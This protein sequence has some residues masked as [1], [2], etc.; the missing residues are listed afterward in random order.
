MSARPLL[1]DLAITASTMHRAGCA[2]STVLKV[3]NKMASEN[4]QEKTWDWHTLN[5]H[6]RTIDGPK[7]DDASGLVEWMMQRK[8]EHGLAAD[9]HTDSAGH[10]ERVFFE[11]EG[12]AE[13]RQQGYH[14]G[15]QAQGEGKLGCHTVLYDTTHGTNGYGMKLGCFMAGPSIVIF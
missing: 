6:F 3:I 12:A 4:E 5:N 2:T 10:L 9:F 11:V 14:T 1:P 7:A 13:W 15:N 8:Y